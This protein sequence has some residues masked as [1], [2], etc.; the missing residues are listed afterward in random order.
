MFNVMINN[1]LL[2]KKIKKNI[3]S[4]S[5]SMRLLRIDWLPDA[6]GMKPLMPEPPAHFSVNVYDKSIS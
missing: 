5:Q 1:I 2:T 3:T 4:S 6:H